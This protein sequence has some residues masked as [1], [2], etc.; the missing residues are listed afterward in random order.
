MNGIQ[1]TADAN[2]RL[3]S[4]S[5]TDNAGWQNDTVRISFDDRDNKIPFP[6]PGDK[7]NVFMGWQ[8]SKGEKKYKNS[9]VY[10][11]EY[12]I[13]EFEYS[14]ALKTLNVIGRANDTGGTLKHVKSRTWSQTDVNYIVTRIASEHSLIPLIEE[15]VGKIEYSNKTQVNQSDQG[16]L[17]SLA[18]EVNA[19]FKVHDGKLYFAKRGNTSAM[20]TGGGVPAVSLVESDLSVY[21]YLK[22]LRSEY[23]TVET[24]YYDKDEGKAKIEKATIA[25]ENGKTKDSS[26]TFVAPDKDSAKLLSNSTSKELQ[27][28][29]ETF[30]FTTVGEPMLRAEH[31]V[32]ISDLRPGIPTTWLIKTA[33]HTYTKSNKLYSTACDCELPI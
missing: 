7:L 13:D 3:L 29:K 21:N 23:S 33:V 8:P 14:N 22:Q 6:K 32:I 18:E 27:R 10:M 31:R 12:W 15:S 25:P 11:G 2:D 28:E 1:V 26:T 24:R 5:V 30:S 4:L 9:L 16:F 20:S 17:T 19:V